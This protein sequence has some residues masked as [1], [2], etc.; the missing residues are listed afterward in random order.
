MDSFTQKQQK[1]QKNI[2]YIQ[3]QKQQKKKWLYNTTLKEKK[4]KQNKNNHRSK[5]RE[6][7]RQLKYHDS[8]EY[9]SPDWC[10]II[11]W[12]Y[13]EYDINRKCDCTQIPF[14]FHEM[15]HHNT[16][17]GAICRSILKKQE[18]STYTYKRAQTEKYMKNG[19]REERNHIACERVLK[20]DGFMCLDLRMIIVQ[21]MK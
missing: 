9:M 18:E 7:S 20:A 6:F 10:F 11:G 5:D 4:E 16:Y 3:N 12:D 8:R 17:R 19:I 14:C 1:Q 21:Y 13:H 15:A 2:S